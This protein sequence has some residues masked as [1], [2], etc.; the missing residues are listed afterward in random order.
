M[1]KNDP[2]FARGRPHVDVNFSGN[3]TELDFLFMCVRKGRSSEYTINICIFKHVTSVL[4]VF[5]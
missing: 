2:A 3:Y 4:F 5:R 1:Y